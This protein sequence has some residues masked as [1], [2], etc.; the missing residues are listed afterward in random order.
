MVSSKKA[1]TGEPRDKRAGR[2][3]DQEGGSGGGNGGQQCL[4]LEMPG[5][6]KLFV[7]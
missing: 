6:M 3:S 5:R 1:M 7:S 4:M 2:C